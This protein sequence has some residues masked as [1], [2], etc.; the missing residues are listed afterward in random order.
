[1]GGWMDGWMD[2]LR[3]QGV[4]LA[5]GVPEQAAAALDDLV[6]GHGQACRY[7]SILKRMDFVEGGTPIAKQNRLVLFY[8]VGWG[9]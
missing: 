8:V 9:G 7:I 6:I 4:E 3:E 1:M 2:Y 5:V